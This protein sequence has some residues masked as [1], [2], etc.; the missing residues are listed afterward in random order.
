MER[1]EEDEPVVRQP[2]QE[3][4][5]AGNLPPES[6]RLSPGNEQLLPLKG[7]RK[8]PQQEPELPAAVGEL[9]KSPKIMSN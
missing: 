9:P 4:E 5:S 1:P 7:A 3:P 8:N 6:E 2:H